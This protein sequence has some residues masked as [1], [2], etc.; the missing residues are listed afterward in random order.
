MVTMQLGG[1][2]FTLEVARM[3]LS[4]EIGLMFRDAMPA[5]HGMIFVFPEASRLS[6]WMRNTRIP[7]DIVYVGTDQR[8]VSV[9]QMKPYDESQ[10][11]AAGPAKWAIELNE[12]TAAK[13]G[14][15]AGQKLDIPAEALQAVE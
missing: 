12:G 15:Q 5:D 8:I 7:L 1:K 13:L 4:R 6:F 10:T 9:H 14:L 11:T 3:D 2:T